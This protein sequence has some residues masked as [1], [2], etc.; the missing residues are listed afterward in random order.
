HALPQRPPTRYDQAPATQLGT[1]AHEAAREL[2]DAHLAKC[3]AQ[4][5]LRSL[6]ADQ[7]APRQRV[8]LERTALDPLLKAARVD[9]VAVEPDGEQG[10]YNSAHAHARDPVD[11]P[12]C[13]AEFLQHADVCKG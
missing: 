7:G 13:R 1:P 11:G 9:L 4:H 8:V 3:P 10:A 12:A 2:L 6:T 5:R